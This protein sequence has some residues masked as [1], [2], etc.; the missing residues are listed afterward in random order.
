MM[1]ID[2]LIEPVAINYDFWK[3]EENSIPPQ[4]YIAWFLISFVML[5]MSEKILTKRTNKLAIV[6]FITQ[7]LFF[8]V[9]NVVSGHFIN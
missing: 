5:L 6:L 4:N 3:W 9:I 1:G 8:L 7:L 2:F